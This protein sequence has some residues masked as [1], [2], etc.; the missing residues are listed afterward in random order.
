MGAN[1][2]GRGWEQAIPKDY[3]AATWG[4]YGRNGLLTPSGAQKL[5]TMLTLPQAGSLEGGELNLKPGG[6][7]TQRAWSVDNY[8]GDFRI[9]DG[10]GNILARSSGG[11][12]VDGTGAKYQRL[13]KETYIRVALNAN[14]VIAVNTWTR[15]NWLVELGD[16]NGNFYNAQNG[17]GPYF[18]APEEG[19]Y[20]FSIG[21]FATYGANARVISSVFSD[22]TITN[23]IIRVIDTLPSSV[24]ADG[25]ATGTAQAYLTAGQKVYFGLLS[26][27][28]G[29]TIPANTVL[30]WMIITRVG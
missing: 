7:G 18:E 3:Q 28:A 12:L 16:R 25:T 11:I 21:L 9:F 27:G 23:E 17:I 15:L 22:Y 24:A 30:T 8:N 29:I 13:N 6:T 26:L 4:E 14:Q 19:V 2:G 10:S 1:Y 5:D 20:S